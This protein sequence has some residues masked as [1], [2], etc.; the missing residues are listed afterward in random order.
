MKYI[1]IKGLFFIYEL[2]ICVII[3][4]T[5]FILE[6]T[7][8]E[9]KLFKKNVIVIIFHSLSMVFVHFLLLINPHITL[10]TNET[11]PGFNAN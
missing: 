6:S 1:Y 5:C 3:L 11:A 4:P 2:L 8:K 7:A 10:L 9:E